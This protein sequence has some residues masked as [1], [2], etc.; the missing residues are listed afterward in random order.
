MHGPAVELEKDNASE[1]K[2]RLGIWMFLVYAFVYM[3]FVAI[4]TIKPSLMEMKIGNLN[5]A[6]V[7][8]F[9]LIIFALIQA[10]YY[11]NLCSK[12]E[13]KLNK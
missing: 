6:I 11:N 10:L 8:G 1:Y 2:T 5:L 12:A 13:D 4:N 9:G 3:G 7:Y